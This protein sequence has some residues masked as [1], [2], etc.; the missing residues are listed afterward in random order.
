[1]IDK[2]KKMKELLKW[3]DEIIETIK[4]DDWLALME[5]ERQE[6]EELNDLTDLDDDENEKDEDL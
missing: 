4:E 1:M 2:E 3:F 5:E 6:I